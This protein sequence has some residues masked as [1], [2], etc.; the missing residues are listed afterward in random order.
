MKIHCY[1]NTW[2]PLCHS[3]VRRNE[4][5]RRTGTWDN[6]GWMAT[7]TTRLFRTGFGKRYGHLSNGTGSSLWRLGKERPW[8]RL[9]WPSVPQA[10]RMPKMRQPMAPLPR[11][12]RSFKKGEARKQE[13]FQR[14]AC[15]LITRRTSLFFRLITLPSGEGSWEEVIILRFYPNQTNSIC[16]SATPPWSIHMGL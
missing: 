1:M 14:T 15:G 10:R 16:E 4:S 7:S 6:L 3:I 5:Q 11:S 9:F 2:N 12:G 13:T 8:E